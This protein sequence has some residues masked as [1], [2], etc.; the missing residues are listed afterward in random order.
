[1]KGT[2]VYGKMGALGVSCF[3]GLELG[4]WKHVFWNVFGGIF[5]GY[6]SDFRILKAF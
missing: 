1:L 6:V 5:L 3:G 2:R 4:F